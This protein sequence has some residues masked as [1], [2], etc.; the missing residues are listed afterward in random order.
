VGDAGDQS[1]LRGLIHS[2]GGQ[3]LATSCDSG[4]F[5]GPVKFESCRG[6]ATSLCRVVVLS[7]GDAYKFTISDSMALRPL[8]GR[9]WAS[10]EKKKLEESGKTRLRERWRN[11]TSLSSASLLLAFL[12]LSKAHIA[13][14]ERKI[15]H[16]VDTDGDTPTHG[17]WRSVHCQPP[18]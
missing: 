2:F 8:P 11:S 4:G 10:R 7:Q 17:M 16:R 12:A 14:A 18:T 6:L 5:S 1:T 15:V 3:K 13:L 9:T